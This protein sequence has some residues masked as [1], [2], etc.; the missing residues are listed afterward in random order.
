MVAKTAHGNSDKEKEK[1]Y[2]DMIKALKEENK[3]LKSVM[4]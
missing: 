4:C 1:K 3:K 2:A